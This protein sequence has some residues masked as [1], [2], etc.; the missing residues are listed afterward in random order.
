MVLVGVTALSFYLFLVANGQN[1]VLS[2]FIPGLVW[3]VISFM[4]VHF[5]GSAEDRSLQK[6]ALNSI[7]GLIGF[8]IA[9]IGGAYSAINQQLSL[10]LITV[11]VSSVLS[12]LSWKLFQKQIPAPFTSFQFYDFWKRLTYAF[13]AE[14]PLFELFHY[15]KRIVAGRRIMNPDAVAQMLTFRD[16]VFYSIL[17]DALLFL[18]LGI[19]FL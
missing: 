17:I 1:S 19:S 9:L 15:W 7:P 2:I 18:I 11:L 13:L 6:A 16:A 8:A 14:P 12:Y 5:L 4:F 10:F 3:I